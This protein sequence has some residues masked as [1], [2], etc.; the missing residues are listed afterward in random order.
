MLAAAVVASTAEAPVLLLAFVIVMPA[1]VI[2]VVFAYGPATPVPFAT[3]PVP[4]APVGCAVAFAYTVPFAVVVALI[5]T[6]I[7]P[8]PE[9]AVAFCAADVMTAPG[10]VVTL[11]RMTEPEVAV[12][13]ASMAARTEAGTR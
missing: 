10:A 11:E 6:G 9:S 13:V 3:P 4:T 1:I 8:R 2:L 12:G 5:M 7:A